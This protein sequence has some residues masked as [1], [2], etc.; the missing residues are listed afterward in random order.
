MLNNC[1]LKV[2]QGEMGYAKNTFPIHMCMNAHL[3][4]YKQ[5]PNYYYTIV[6]YIIIRSSVQ[7]VSN[8]AGRVI[9]HLQLMG[10]PP[11]VFDL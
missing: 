10:T 11:F 7:Y 2:S 1:V 6:F 8:Q 4:K 3:Y 9:L 5:P